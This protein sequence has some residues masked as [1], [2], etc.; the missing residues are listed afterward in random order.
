MER[1]PLAGLSRLAKVERRAAVNPATA[2]VGLQNDFHL[3]MPGIIAFALMM[4]FPQTAMLAARENRQDT[5][6]LRLT[7]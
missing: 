3:Y 5:R 1:D 2:R 7:G 4:I 6:W